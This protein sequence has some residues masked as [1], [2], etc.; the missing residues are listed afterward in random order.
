LCITCKSID[1]TSVNV[2]LPRSMW[3]FQLNFG[4]VLTVVFFHCITN[5]YEYLNTWNNN[6]CVRPKSTKFNIGRILKIE[7]TQSVRTVPKF[8]WKN[9][10]DRGKITLTEVKSILLH[11]IHND[12]YMNVHI[13]WYLGVIVAVIV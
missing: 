6:F 4:T 2:I 13:Q 5:W 7:G 12:I 3:F 8:N 1:F 11:V 9:H 10:I